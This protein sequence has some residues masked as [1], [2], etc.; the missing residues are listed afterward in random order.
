MRLL[1]VS[2]CTRKGDWS[3]VPKILFKA[4][5]RLGRGIVASD[6]AMNSRLGNCLAW[7]VMCLPVDPL[8]NFQSFA[9]RATAGLAL[10]RNI[11]S[12]DLAPPYPMLEQCTRCL[13]GNRKMRGDIGDAYPVMGD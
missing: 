2:E 3:L 6:Q 11:K 10:A 4:E 1:T 12:Q 7:F 8:V 13:R 9:A 5:V